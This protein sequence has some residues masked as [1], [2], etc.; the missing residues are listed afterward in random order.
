M[1]TR[2]EVKY[3]T[4]NSEILRYFLNLPVAGS[5]EEQQNSFVQA[6]KE[7]INSLE[8]NHRKQTV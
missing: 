7:V 3:V 4:Q 5:S 6:L 2:S 8:N 1:P